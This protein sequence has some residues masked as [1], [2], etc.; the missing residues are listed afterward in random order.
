M[1]GPFEIGLLLA[2]L[3]LGPLINF[4]IYSFAYFPR[5]IS[6]WQAPPSGVAARSLAGKLPILGWFLRTAES[7]AFGRLFWLRPLLIEIAT[8]ILLLLLY[9]YVMSDGLVPLGGL[10]TVVPAAL[11]HQFIACAALIAL[12]AIATFIDFDERTIPDWV[13]IPGTLFGLVGGVLMPDWRMYEMS[14]PV[15]PAL[16]GT[17]VALH[18]NS[19]FDWDLAWNNGAPGNMGLWF[20]LLFWTGW[21][22]G[23]ADRRWIVRRGFKKA[24][25]YFLETLRRSPS[26][27]LLSTMW[28]IGLACILVAYGTLPAVRWE[29]LLSS[30]FGIGLGGLLV[31]GFRLVARW[32]MGQEAL[33]FGDVTLMAMIG[34]FFGWQI[35]W[36]AFF[37]APFFGLIFV[38]VV[39]VVTRDNATP[40]GPYL[41]AATLYA[42][43]DWNKLWGWCSMLFFP[44]QMILPLLFG[45]LVA[46][47]VMLW[48]VQ[49]IKGALFGVDTQGS[50]S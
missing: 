40:F 37:M 9:R 39:W 11:F 21:C 5:P 20:G 4:G 10:A 33:G 47:A 44:P 8:P 27:R 38:I 45:L 50:R 26:T 36:I 19:P 48:I 12:M 24:I 16:V 49:I 29:A 34:A 31:W 30:L 2:G 35:V 22:F 32:A 13:T 23:M 25:V 1:F 41:C 43:L 3:I 17:P 18:A 6:P 7:T 42:I 15:P 14:P 28:G 46:L